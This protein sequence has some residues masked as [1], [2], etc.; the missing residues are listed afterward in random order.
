[1]EVQLTD[2]DAIIVGG[3]PAGLTAGIYLARARY[4]V[5]LLEK[6]QF[7]GQLLNIA[8]IENYPGFAEGVEGTKLASEMIGQATKYGVDLEQDQV[9]G[10]DSYSSCFSVNC[11]TGTAY[12]S[13]AIILAS[14]S[15][16]RKLNV[17]GEDKFHGQGV[18][19]CALCDGGQFK[20]RVFAVC[21]GGDAGVTEALYMTNL[22]SKVIL[23]EAMSYLTATQIYQERAASNPKM[24]IHCGQKIVEIIGDDR[25]KAIVVADVSTTRKETLHVDG[26]LV[27][28]G[29]VP[30]TVYI[31]GVVPLD[32]SRRVEVNQN[33]ETKVPGI[34][35]AGDLR[36]GSPQQISVAVGDGAIAAI[37]AQ[38]FLQALSKDVGLPARSSSS[39]ED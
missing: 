19:H 25:V 29:V 11:R 30:N 2:Y 27:H 28:V 8:W 21:G 37:A 7:G 18:I 32:A 4:R 3:G 38:R 34:F 31:E 14:G 10:I 39:N 22:A 36:Q 12:T 5:L 26:L 1:L 24:E 17:P 23:I 16:S 35:A 13:S 9:T 6:D 20:N 33:L 15:T